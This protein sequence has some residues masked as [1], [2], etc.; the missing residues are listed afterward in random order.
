MKPVQIKEFHTKKTYE[1]E[2]STLPEVYITI[3]GWKLT[4]SPIMINCPS[5]DH[6]PLNVAKI[7]SDY[8]TA[9]YGLTRLHD[10]NGEY[11]YTLMDGAICVQLLTDGD[12]AYYS[13]DAVPYYTD[14][15]ELGQKVYIKNELVGQL[16]DFTYKDLKLGSFITPDQ[17]P[18]YLHIT[19][20]PVKHG[21]N[22]PLGGLSM[23]LHI[24][25]GKHLEYVLI[26]CMP[27]R[28]VIAD[29]LLML[30]DIE[31]E[32]TT[33][34]DT[35]IFTSPSSISFHDIKEINASCIYTFDILAYT[36]DIVRRLGRDNLEVLK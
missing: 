18:V 21:H 23:L 13:I 15:T 27:H 32:E 16:R 10:L 14:L 30:L 3:A 11:T 33:V 28:I 36:Y 8:Y 4:F 7:V 2:D 35:Y 12:T 29:D 5:V 26:N 17:E 34:D 25:T 19:D 1:V 24:L 22:S 31:P 20:T 9:G 6:L